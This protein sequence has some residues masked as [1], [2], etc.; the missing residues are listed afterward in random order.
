MSGVVPGRPGGRGSATPSF[1]LPVGAGTGIPG[2]LGETR[3]G[4]TTFRWGERTVVM[5]IVNVTPDSF[6]DGG[7]Y[8]DP[9]RA[10]AHGEQ[11]AHDGADIVDIGGESTRPGARPI[12][13]DEEIS[14]VLPVI[15]GLRAKISLPI[16]IDTTKSEVARAALDEGADVVND[17]SA[18]GFDPAMAPLVAREKAPIVLMHMQGTPRI[19]QQ[20][21][22]Y[23]NVVEE[24]KEFLR[25]RVQFALAA[26]VEADKIIVDPGIGFGKNIEHNLALLRGLGALADL[27]RPILVG[28]SRKT[29][30]GKLLDAAPEE[31]LEGSLAAAV[32]AALAGANIVRVHDVKEAARAVRVADALRFGAESIG[33]RHA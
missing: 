22:F 1:A 27:G 17:I 20:N 33:A 10:V 6:S 8:F 26:G 3:I 15:R 7:K 24:V 19:M 32:A 4:G 23:E 12:S 11:M 21:P 9:S 31:R 29:F 28:T 13:A 5:G 2:P 16:S 14:R 18:L 25:R 30:I